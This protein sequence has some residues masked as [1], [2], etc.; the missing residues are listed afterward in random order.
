MEIKAELKK[1]Y[2]EDQRCKFII[3]QNYDK[4]YEIEEIDNA[5]L[6]WGYTEEEKQQQKEERVA[7]LTMTALDFIG[8][9][10]QFGLSLQQINDHLESHLELK[11]QLTYCQKVYC[12]VVQALCPLVV[13][14]KT[15]TKEMV[16]NAFKDKNNEIEVA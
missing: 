8:V 16:I 5:I 14:D 4:G 11:M 7:N 6:A 2:T 12:G 10:Q 13:Y 15:I 3:E 9:L 1:P